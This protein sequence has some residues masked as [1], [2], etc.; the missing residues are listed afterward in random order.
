MSAKL[1]VLCILASITAIGFGFMSVHFAN[2]GVACDTLT[3]TGDITPETFLSAKEC[4]VQSTARK[5]T[6]VVTRSGGGSWESALALGILIH[7]HG[8]DVE[9]VDVC[10]SACANF[11]FPAG[12]VKYVNSDALL[13]FH[14]GPHQQN[15]SAKAAEVEQKAM[16]SEQPAAVKSMP[17]ETMDP[18]HARMEGHVSIDGRGAERLQVMEFLSI[19]NVSNAADLLNR[20]TI[21]SDQF[22]EELGVNRL[23][24]IYGQLG[25]YEPTYKSYK[26]GGFIYRLDSLRRL[27]LGNIELK[28][29]EWR[30]ERNPNYRD[31]YEVTYP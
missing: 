3:L 23:L 20:L 1:K 2:A 10:A 28:N 6:F 7:R 18:E 14:G 4:L 27:G 31:V 13:L 21:A 11:I 17:S 25:S 12:K 8:W 29:G 15:I 5:K 24:P 26:Y 9:I 22:Y 19:K 16:E 30:P